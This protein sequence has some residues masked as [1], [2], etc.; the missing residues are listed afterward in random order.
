MEKKYY[1]YLCTQ[2]NKHIPFIFLGIFE[3]DEIEEFTL[4]QNVANGNQ[5]NNVKLPCSTQRQVVD[6][7]TIQHVK[8]AVPELTAFET[9]DYNYKHDKETHVQVMEKEIGADLRVT[10]IEDVIEDEQPRP[11]PPPPTRPR[12]VEIIE[13]PISIK[14]SSTLTSSGGVL[15]IDDVNKPVNP[16]SINGKTNRTKEELH[17]NEESHHHHHQA[18]ST[19]IRKQFI[20]IETKKS[21]ILNRVRNQ[22][23]QIVIG[24][25]IHH[26]NRCNHH[27]VDLGIEKRQIPDRITCDIDDE[28][29][30]KNT[31]RREI[32]IVESFVDNNNND[33]EDEESYS[34]W[35]EVYTVTIRGIRYKILWVYDTIKA[36]R[37]T[38][39]EAVQR[40]LV[41]LSQN[42][43]HN[44]KI[45]Y[46]QTIAEAADDGLIGIEEDNSA[47][48]LNVNGITYT[49]Y[50]VWD[51]V[52][53]KRISPKKAI[54]IG[55]LDTTNLLY[56]N[57]VNNEQ[58]TI[59]EAVYMK[60]IGASD[61]LS[62]IDEELTLCVNGITYKIAWVKDSRTKEKYKPR[63]ALRRGLFN[64]RNFLYNKY[65][66]N[67]TLTIQEAVDMNLIGLS[68]VD[69]GRRGVDDDEDSASTCSSASD[70]DCSKQNSTNG[71]QDSIASL[72]DEE[73]T[74]RT[75]TAIYVITGLLHPVT[76]KEIKVSEAIAQGIL[77]KETGAYR[78]FKTE[79][80]YEVGEAI[81][82]G[83]VFAT[84]TDLLQDEQASTEFIREEI[85]RFIVKSVVDPRD[86][87]VIG[88]LQ[89]QAA[90]ILNYAQGMYTNPESGDQI[91]IAEAIERKLIE[92]TLQEESAHEEFDAE[93]VTDSLMERCTTKY[94][95]LEV[96]DPFSNE[97]ISASEAVRRQIID[98]ETNAYVDSASSSL[99][100]IPIRE[101]VR[102][103][104]IKAEISEKVERKPL[105]LSLQNAMRLGLFS[106]ES[107]KFRDPY[108][109]A[110]MDLNAAIEK[111]HINPNGPAVADS[112]GAMST[113]GGS[114]TLNEAFQYSIFNKRTG[115]LD[116][117]RLQMFKAKLVESTSSKIFKW[118]F[119]DAVKCGLINIKTAK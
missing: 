33:D 13:K 108:T 47:L 81:N 51:P 110:V 9:I 7:N 34:E 85:R 106:I 49:I 72:D 48:I 102:R 67:E 40:G 1:I 61:D 28:S 37:V 112:G 107:A 44:L 18:D 83:V 101:A 56:K 104:L 2:R 46:S 62:N 16:V 69:G 76:Q 88:G 91:P 96:L 84:V 57:Y 68:N 22:Q 38:L 25:E 80:T 59:H 58:I 105:G 4:N 113:G 53:S 20:E 79:V 23:A 8:P 31:T 111:G 119:D 55:V 92:V 94:K 45:S 10:R 99:T 54:R 66:S 97:P 70:L 43:Y 11:R 32:H 65:D 73:L 100:F 36:E 78:D 89:A 41:N 63:Q 52:K 27:V 3:I 24:E 64:L 115:C 29:D 114:M 21:E 87:Q 116:R 19:E 77:N 82:E 12:P 118:N 95:I 117:Q 103:N 30:R 26:P 15:V 14:S 42:V 98:T 39:N 17:I 60:L 6:I 86:G 50:W 93:V 74:I 90:G 35:T 5:T 109:S 75:K 71:R